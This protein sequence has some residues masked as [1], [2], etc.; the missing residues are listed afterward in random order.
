[1]QFWHFSIIKHKCD[2][3]VVLSIDDKI[4]SYLLHATSY[5]LPHRCART[6]IQLSQFSK[7]SLCLLVGKR[8]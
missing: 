6:W 7:Q 3:A 1:M 8:Q 5:R 4:R 2:S